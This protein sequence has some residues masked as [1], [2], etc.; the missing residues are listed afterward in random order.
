MSKNTSFI[1]AAGHAVRFS[2]STKQLFKIGNETVI[3]RIVRQVLDR[4]SLPVV[5]TIHDD[6]RSVVQCPVFTPKVHDVVCESILSTSH[7]W[8]GRTTILLGDVVYSRDTMDRIFSCNA[9]DVIVFGNFWERFAVSFNSFSVGDK[10][11]FHLGETARLAN[12]EK[13]TGGKV[14]HF[15]R[16][17]VGFP[18]D[19]NKTEPYHFRTVNDYTNDLDSLEFYNNFVRE[20]VQAGKLDD[21]K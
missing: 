14:G 11:R 6:I 9:E 16:H 8:F 15:Y 5:V 17:Y 2:G 1:M 7:L 18:L 4:G 3:E 21:L 10:V 20:V 12:K 13:K 19:E